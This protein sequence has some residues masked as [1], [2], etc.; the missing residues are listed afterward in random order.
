MP[1]T[2]FATAPYAPST[3]SAVASYA[4]STASAA[5]SYAS[6]ATF[7][8]LLAALPTALLTVPPT[9]TAALPTV[10][11]ASVSVSTTGSITPATPVA[12]REPEDRFEDDP[13]PDFD[14]ADFEALLRV[15]VLRELPDELRVLLDFDPLDELFEDDPADRLDE[16]EE[17]R[18][19]PDFEAVEDPV[20]LPEDAERADVERPFELPLLCMSVESSFF[21]TSRPVFVELLLELLLLVA[22]AMTHPF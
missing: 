20:D 7:P 18:L 13:E 3:A 21:S 12:L 9:E 5:T 6:E 10:S 8:A 19:A 1:P 16:G 2:D 4:S 17:A 14:E 11:A 15:P 22:C